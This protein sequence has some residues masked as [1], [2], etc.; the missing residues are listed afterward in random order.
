MIGSLLVAVVLTAG[1]GPLLVKHQAKT[2]SL[3]VPTDWAKSE[4]EGTEKFNS[5]TGQAFFTLDVG[6]VQTAGMK[7]QVCLDK[8]MAAMGTEGWEK[9]K[10]GSNPAAKRINVDNANKDG[11]Q[12]LR[13]I[14]YVG[15]NGKTTWSIIFSINE[16]VKDQFEPLA[17]QIVQSI[18]Y[19]KGM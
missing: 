15:C 3:G 9:L 8:M 18:V 6:A 14:T 7:A 16:Q 17:G 5:P 13:S 1:S 4:Q 12:K 10:A 19:T 11:S 2:L